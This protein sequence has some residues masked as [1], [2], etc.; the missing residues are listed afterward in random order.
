MTLVCRSLLVYEIESWKPEIGTVFKL[1][2]KEKKEKGIY[3]GGPLSGR[4]AQK[5]VLYEVTGWADVLLVKSMLRTC[6]CK[7]K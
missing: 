3:I 5:G 7:N 6:D 1:E 4:L 2:A